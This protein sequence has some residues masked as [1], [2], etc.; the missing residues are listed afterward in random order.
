[1]ER[2][3][4]RVQVELSACVRLTLAGEFKIPAGIPGREMHS[5][6]FWE[7]L[8]MTKG[9]AG[10]RWA[11]SQTPFQEG[12]LIL[13]PPMAEHM[14]EAG[15][16][17]LEMLYLGFDFDPAIQIVVEPMRLS[18]AAD[19]SWLANELPMELRRLAQ[20]SLQTNCAIVSLV[21]RMFDQLLDGVKET[22]RRSRASV[23]VEKA[24][25][26]IE[27]DLTR[28]VSVKKLAA[29]F[30]L[31]PHHF[32]ELFREETGAT[33]KE[34]HRRMRMEK[35]L[36]LLR[37]SEKTAG[38]IAS[39]MGYASL[40]AFSRDFKSIFGVSPNSLRRK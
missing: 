4:E 37:A 17:P 32:G 33:V 35:A 36:R 14:V 40:Q 2:K 27:S 1:M 5:H 3:G 16:N 28:G 6:P 29:M 39:E 20:K 13:I 25:A 24:K 15:A 11:T 31:T 23:L 19:F 34:C 22:P 10:L 7:L 8:M 30:Y 12:S 9:D 38:E 21:A 26:V 18:P